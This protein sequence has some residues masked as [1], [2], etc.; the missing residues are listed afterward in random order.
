MQLPFALWLCCAQ[1]HLYHVCVTMNCC[2][3]YLTLWLGR[4][5]RTQLT[6]GH[7]GCMVSLIIHDQM[8]CLYENPGANKELFFEKCCSWPQM[9]WR[10]PRTPGVYILLLGCVINSI[11]IFFPLQKPQIPWVLPDH[12]VH[13]TWLLVLLDLLLSPFLLW[14]PIKTGSLLCHPVYGMK[15]SFQVWNMLPPKPK[16]DCQVCASFLMGQ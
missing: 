11:G 2:W 9:A 8:I 13:T 1:P 7:F 15:Q 6:I 12:M 5:D 16:E 14:A 10:C 3:P 4:P